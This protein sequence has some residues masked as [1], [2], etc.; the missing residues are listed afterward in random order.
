MSYLHVPDHV[1][2][3]VDL[4]VAKQMVD[5]CAEELANEP[6]NKLSIFDLSLSAHT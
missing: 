4:S 6:L 5:L 1:H 2:Q 3:H